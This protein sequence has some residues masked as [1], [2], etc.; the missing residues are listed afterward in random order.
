[1]SAEH[2]GAQ[3]SA[4]NLQVRDR[5]GEDIT[6]ALQGHDRRDQLFELLQGGVAIR[7]GNPAHSIEVVSVNEFGLLLNPVIQDLPL[8]ELAV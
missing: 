2:R 6:L 5:L 1:L 3:G 7:V 4:Q 8:L